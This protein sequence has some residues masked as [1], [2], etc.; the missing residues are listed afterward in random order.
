MY[1]FK[2]ALTLVN[3]GGEL[4]KAVFTIRCTVEHYLNNIYK[5]FSS[6]CRSEMADGR[7]FTIINTD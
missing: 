4:H 2:S 1:F 3:Q 5:H 7:D 6:D